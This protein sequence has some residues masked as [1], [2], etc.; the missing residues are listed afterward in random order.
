MPP[1]NGSA[2]FQTTST[3]LPIFQPGSGALRSNSRTTILLFLMA[4]TTTPMACTST[5][6]VSFHGSN[7]PTP[8]GPEVL[9][10][11]K[12]NMAIKVRLDNRPTLF[13][14]ESQ[15]CDLLVFMNR[16]SKI[17]FDEVLLF[18]IDDCR[19]WARALTAYQLTEDNVSA[20]DEFINDLI[21]IESPI[22]PARRFG[23][24]NMSPN[25]HT[26]YCLDG[27]AES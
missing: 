5:T 1:Y 26:A 2:G 25:L 15:I 24:I 27:L 8:I 21:S 18:S 12:N 9:M 23:R 10:P 22:L 19:S 13:Q 7:A 6:R 3:N 16:I 14:N 4:I 20:M 11:V 17:P